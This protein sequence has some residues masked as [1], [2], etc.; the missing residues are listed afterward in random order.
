MNQA[1]ARTSGPWNEPRLSPAARLH[2]LCD[3]GAAPKAALPTGVATNCAVE[4]E[5]TRQGHWLWLGKP[6]RG[7]TLT[8]KV[9]KWKQAPL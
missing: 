7:T 9:C 3:V 5:G 4:L 1:T 6:E 8:L 2:L